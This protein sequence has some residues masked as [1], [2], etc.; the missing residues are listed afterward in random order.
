MLDDVLMGI[1][2]GI[3]AERGG[4]ASH[5]SALAQVKGSTVR[6]KK[7]KRQGKGLTD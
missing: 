7:A 2:D 5:A 3:L 1:V 4:I 6:A